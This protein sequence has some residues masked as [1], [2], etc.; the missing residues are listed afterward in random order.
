MP[1]GIPPPRFTEPA[2]PRHTTTVQCAAA[3]PTLARIAAVSRCSSRAAGHPMPQQWY[4]VLH[5]VPW[6]SRAHVWLIRS[7][8]EAS[9]WP[10]QLHPQADTSRTFESG[11]ASR[12]RPDPS[13]THPSPRVPPPRPP[14]QHQTRD[15]DS[16]RT[17]DVAEPALLKAEQNDTA[18]TLDEPMPP[19]VLASTVSRA[20]VCDSTAVAAWS[21]S[22]PPLNF[23]AETVA[24]TVRR[25]E[26]TISA[27]G[28][29]PQD[30]LKAT[31]LGTADTSAPRHATGSGA[32]LP[33]GISPSVG[34]DVITQ[35]F[36]DLDG[37]SRWQNAELSAVSR[38]FLAATV[39]G[40]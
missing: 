18:G 22:A 40:G 6:N 28:P 20:P 10:S 9:S 23:R 3:S 29:S 27:T 17:S 24:A 15:S 34:C 8:R 35:D 11:E 39:H 32:E 19:L 4:P 1:H 14:Q 2:A 30:N 13:R 25:I 26:S 37:S 38:R 5:G 33:A 21:L 7:L 31:G 36:A 16:S 12:K